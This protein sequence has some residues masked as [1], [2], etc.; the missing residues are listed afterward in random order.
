[1]R[2]PDHTDARDPRVELLPLIDVV[3]LVLAAFIYASLFLTQRSGLPISLP[4]ATQTESQ[5]LEV[6]TLAITR[7]G[8]LYLDE[9]NLSLAELEQALRMARIVRPDAVL[10]VMA[11][12][13]TNVGRLV[14]VMDTT[15]IAGITELTIQAKP[16]PNTVAEQ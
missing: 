14:Q 12:R 2:I 4:E 7:E 9:Q 6:I 15:R 5:L 11:D 10:V 3:F 1:M 13:D 8:S 16:K